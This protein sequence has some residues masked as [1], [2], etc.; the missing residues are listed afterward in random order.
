MGDSGHKGIM[1]HL[2]M[3]PSDTPIAAISRCGRSQDKIVSFLQ[4]RR[5]G[6]GQMGQIR[7][8]TQEAVWWHP[9]CHGRVVVL[10][11]RS[12]G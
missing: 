5:G 10:R 6:V 1:L 2:H 12:S 7:V 3:Q 11:L 4:P 9:S 8:Q